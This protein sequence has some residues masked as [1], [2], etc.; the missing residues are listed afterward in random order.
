M[1]QVKNVFAL[2]GNVDGFGRHLSGLF[3]AAITAGKRV[4]SETSIA[5]GAVSVSSAAAEL[6]Q[7]K[8]PGGNFDG[9]RV[10]IVGAGTMSRLLVKHLVSKRCTEMTIVNRSAG[11]VEELM[12]DFP[13]A[14]I[15]LALMD[16]FLAQAEKHDVIFT[17]ASTGV[18]ITKADLATMA[19]ANPAGAGTRRLGD[20]R[21]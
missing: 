5:S 2:G 14:N 21:L 15:K 1:S 12:A 11:R 20:R 9:C 8:L 16:D 19:P 17:A 13:E 6:V 7:M 3:K 10:M 4:R 18:I